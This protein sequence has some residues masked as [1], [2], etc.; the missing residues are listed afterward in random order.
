M[1]SEETP[2]LAT[3]YAR[4]F[5]A[6]TKTQILAGMNDRKKGVVTKKAH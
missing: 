2:V 6:S 4:G 5:R 3:G 1:T